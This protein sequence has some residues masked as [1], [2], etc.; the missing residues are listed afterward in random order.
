MLMTTVTIQGLLKLSS[1]LCVILL[2]RLELLCLGLLHLDGLRCN[3]SGA[4][5]NL[6]P[7]VM[8]WP[9]YKTDHMQQVLA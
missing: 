3:F 9:I 1:C 8:H 2:L 6:P 4:N 5:I 7:P